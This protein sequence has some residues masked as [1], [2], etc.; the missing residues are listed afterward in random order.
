MRPLGAFQKVVARLLTVTCLQ[1]KASSSA[2]LP[3][4]SPH[5]GTLIHTRRMKAAHIVWSVGARP[6][7]ESRAVL[8]LPHYWATRLENRHFAFSQGH[9]D[10]AQI[11]VL[12]FGTWDVCP[13][14]MKFRVRCTEFQVSS[15]MCHL[16]LCLFFFPTSVQSLALGL[17]C[18]FDVSA[19]RYSE[20]CLPRLPHPGMGIRWQEVISLLQPLVLQKLSSPTRKAVPRCP[21]C[22]LM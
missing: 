15:H 6:P 2:L 3:G 9:R 1:Q 12:L 13:P 7:P 17:L 21:L 11:C 20:S 16:L 22:F 4:K 5:P 14:S 8:V 18:R 10:Q 19:A